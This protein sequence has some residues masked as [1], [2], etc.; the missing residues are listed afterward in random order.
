MENQDKYT[1]KIENTPIATIDGNHDLTN[2]HE[3]QILRSQRQLIRT[4]RSRYNGPRKWYHKFSDW[5]AE[6]SGTMF[7]LVL[8]VAWFVIWV[9]WNNALIPGLPVFDP[10]P[11]SFLTMVVS[12]EA[13]V[14]SIVVLISQNRQSN[15]ADLREEIDFNINVRAEHEIT[16]IINLLD[17]IHDHLGMV[18]EE[19]AELDEMKKA[20]D[21]QE[22]EEQLAS[23]Y[24]KRK[25][26]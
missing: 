18:K 1:Q 7:F 20:T 11:H 14:L 22:I 10:Y 15:I 26:S 3:A 24:G 4:F 12:L 23:E 2:T 19:D 17:K 21:L 13:I 9:I 16:K 25:R 5:I 6:I 8:N